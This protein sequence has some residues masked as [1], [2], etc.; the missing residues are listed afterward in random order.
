MKYGRPVL[1]CVLFILASVPACP[2]SQDARHFL[3]ALEA[4]KAGDYT[5][6]ISGWQAI[7]QSGVQ[8]GKL[9][10]NLGNAC[11]KAKQLGSAIYWYE[12]A[13]RLLPNDP[14]L[15]FNYDYARSLT[16]DAPEEGPSPLVR[17]F[18]FWNYQL[19]SRT[20]KILAIGFNLLF[21]LLAMVWRLTRRRAFRRAALLALVPVVVFTLT[22]AFNYYAAAHRRQAIILPENVAVRSGLE[23]SSTELFTLH[24]GAKVNV[25]KTLKGHYQIRFSREKI[26]WVAEKNLGL[27]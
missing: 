24:A 15:R 11:L 23:T 22:T 18:F 12:R 17:I 10:Y 19:S 4:Y 7:A 26:G 2:A 27:I 14:D 5:T 16:Q 6:A 13:L 9:F 25:L 1:W 21:W 8:N 3:A 20:I